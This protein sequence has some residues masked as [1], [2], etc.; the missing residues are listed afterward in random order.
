MSWLQ[1]ILALVEA[2]PSLIKDIEAIVEALTVK[3]APEQAQ[4]KQVLSSAIAS[5]DAS[6][7]QKAIDSLKT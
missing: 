4:A 5:K 3:S 1:I 6:L 7:M 2:L